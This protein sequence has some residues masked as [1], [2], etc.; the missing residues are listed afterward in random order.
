MVKLWGIRQGI[1]NFIQFIKQ[2]YSS[3]SPT[4]DDEWHQHICLPLRLG[5]DVYER[6]C[7]YSQCK[8]HQPEGADAC[9]LC[10]YLVII[11]TTQDQSIRIVGHN[12]FITNFTSLK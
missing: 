6:S 2:P 3:I 1:R 11:D 9:D 7:P 10:K 5:N 8:N 12:Q 4:F